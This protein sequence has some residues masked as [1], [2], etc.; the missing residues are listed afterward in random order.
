MVG[1]EIIE[2]LYSP[3]SAFRKIIEKPD[4]KGVLL[5]LLLVIA[6][7]LAVQYVAGSKQFLESRNPENENWTEELIASHVWT[8]NG[9][10]SLDIS[11]FKIGNSSIKFSVINST[12]IWIKISNI[13][14]IDCSEEMG[15]SELFF[16]IN[17]TNQLEINPS[18][19]TLKVFS[20]NE[21]NYFEKDLSNLLV[22][23]GELKNTTWG[24]ITLNLGPNQEWTSNNSPDW[25]NITEIELELTWTEKSNLTV[26]IDGL[27]FRIFSSS[28]ERG[29]IYFDLISV[30]IQS[31]MTW[32]IWGGLLIIIAKLFNLELGKWNVFF[33]I[34]GYIFMVTVVTNII[35]LYLASTLP[36]L[37][38]LLDATSTFYYS[39][40]S[41]L[42]VE[43]WAFQLL[44]P[45][46][47]I[48][49][50]WTTALSAI[51]IRLMKE[52]TWGKALTISVIAFAAQL[53]L[54][55]IGF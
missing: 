45:I 20:G 49:Y 18:S 17:W 39:R 11:D 13:N 36:D 7:G 15:F 28:V 26:K 10:P 4:F 37:T 30:I 34:I 52:T 38:Y 5:V 27:Y 22:P 33:I 44:T 19:G 35:T 1:K 9:L 23:I 47:W 54:N 8:S 43:S 2:I 6:S 12:N 40:N 32:V 16:W 53:L 25:K 46:I 51:V 42:W 3:V 48:G 55:N 29:T 41:E 50:I 24:N 14:P 21:E 31:G